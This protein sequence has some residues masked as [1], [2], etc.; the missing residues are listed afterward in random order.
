MWCFFYIN[1]IILDITSI[2]VFSITETI[3]DLL[4]LNNDYAKIHK[5]RRPIKSHSDL[6][7]IDKG[8]LRNKVT[9]LNNTRDKL[10][11]KF[12]SNEKLSKKHREYLSLLINDVENRLAKKLN[13]LNNK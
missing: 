12:Y 1:F 11:N 6:T 2:F 7:D 10:L 9:V 3:Y 5:L 4:Y 8:S 13:L